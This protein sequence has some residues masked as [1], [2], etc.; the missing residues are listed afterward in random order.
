MYLSRFYTPLCTS[1]LAWYR[2]QSPQLKGWREKMEYVCWQHADRL[3]GLSRP[4]PSIGKR[5][6]THC[7]AS[8]SSRDSPGVMA[9]SH[10]GP[11]AICIFAHRNCSDI[12]M[13]CLRWCLILN[14]TRSVSFSVLI[15]WCS[16]RCRADFPAHHKSPN[17]YSGFRDSGIQGS[18]DSRIQGFDESMPRRSS[19]LAR[20]R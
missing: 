10:G 9:G 11:A 3:S 8:V 13:R 12:A 18:K 17:K 4:S 2:R 19:A 16:V 15:F 7:C 5:A 1:R 14:N 6:P 20:C